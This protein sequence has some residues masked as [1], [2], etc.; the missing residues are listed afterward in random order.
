MLDR[1]INGALSDR[2]L[3]ADYLW[4]NMIYEYLIDQYLEEIKERGN[5]AIS[6]LEYL[7]RKTIPIK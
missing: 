7:Y 3:D 5:V 6:K 4:R 1:H 2:E